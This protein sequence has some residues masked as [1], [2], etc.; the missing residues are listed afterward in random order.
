MEVV[1]IHGVNGRGEE[2]QALLLA[3]DY[4]R[5]VAAR[6]QQVEL[7]REASRLGAETDGSEP[8]KFTLPFDYQGQAGRLVMKSGPRPGTVHVSVRVEAPLAESVDEHAPRLA[9]EA[10]V[11]SQWILSVTRGA[12][13]QNEQAVRV[14]EALRDASSGDK[15]EGVLKV[16]APQIRGPVRPQWPGVWLPAEYP[17][18]PDDPSLM[19]QLT[20]LFSEIPTDQ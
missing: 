5:Q 10:D 6:A 11:S 17:P 9:I 16:D 1:P 20:E 14:A 7:G 3:V 18:P 4:Q 15:P 13:T 19:A 8:R 2:R 12:S